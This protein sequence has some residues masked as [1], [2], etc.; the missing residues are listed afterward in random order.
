[1]ENR[2]EIAPERIVE[3]AQQ[4]YDIPPEPKK[5]S[6]IDVLR[7]HNVTFNFLTSGCT[8]SVGCKTYAFS[9][10]EEGLG[11][12]IKFVQNPKEAWKKWNN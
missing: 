3:E 6:N 7:R 11:E 5:E 1:M 10:N 4:N 9:N 12:F 8:I 2:V